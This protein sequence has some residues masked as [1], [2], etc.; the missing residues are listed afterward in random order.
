MIGAVSSSD[1][2]AFSDSHRD[3][4]LFSLSLSS[5]SYAVLKLAQAFAEPRDFRRHIYFAMAPALTCVI[6]AVALV[7]LRVY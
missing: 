3:T 7:V 5:G 1:C 4:V 6:S 2:D